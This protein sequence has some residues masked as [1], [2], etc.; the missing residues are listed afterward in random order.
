MKKNRLS[1][2]MDRY[3]ARFRDRYCLMVVLVLHISRRWVS[4]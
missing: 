3:A 2:N 4:N 1:N